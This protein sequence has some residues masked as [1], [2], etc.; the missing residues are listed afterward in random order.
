MQTTLNRLE[1][2]MNE[3]F[4]STLK[5]KRDKIAAIKERLSSVDPKN[6]LKRG[7]TILFLPKK[8]VPL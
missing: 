7:Y 4:R 5:V 1:K 6:V 8:R 3:T 2:Q